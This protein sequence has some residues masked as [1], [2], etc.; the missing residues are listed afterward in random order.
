MHLKHIIVITGAL[1]T[2]IVAFSVSRHT[3]VADGLSAEPGLNVQS[4]LPES[5]SAGAP[6]TAPSASA[7][8]AISHESS[9]TAG[10]S[11]APRADA[12]EAVSATTSGFQMFLPLVV[13]PAGTSAPAAAPAVKRGVG[14]PSPYQYCNDLVTLHTTWFFDWSAQPPSCNGD[15]NVPMIWGSSLPS[16][17]GGNSQWLLV[18]NEPNNPGQANL[19]PTQAALLYPTIETRFA[20]KKLAV[21]NT[22]DG[23]GGLTPGIQWLTAFINAYTQANGKPPRLD[24]IGMHCYQWTA[25]E[26]IQ[27][28]QQIEQLASQ[29]GAEV[30]VTEFAFYQGYD[31]RTV[32]QVQQEMQT[33]LSYLNSE[34]RITHYAWFA[35]RI[36]GTEPWANPAG[37]NSPFSTLT[38]SQPPMGRCTSNDL[39]APAQLS[40]GK[41]ARSRGTRQCMKQLRRTRS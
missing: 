33:Y 32:P 30:W 31:Q 22:Y 7:D 10:G 19:S 25:T 1:L 3:A 26:C 11:K 38:G 9:Q 12:A 6:N 40:R 34:A 35:N 13:R 17:V 8:A 39:Q 21:G 23:Y 16:A 15:E 37:W 20:N 5:K 36:Y 41:L 29:M 27:T 4:A 18:W 2:L 14:T 28:T 24:A